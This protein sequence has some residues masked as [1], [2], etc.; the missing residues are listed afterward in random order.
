MS[1]QKLQKLL[2]NLF[3]GSQ[4]IWQSIHII[5]AHPS[6]SCLNGDLSFF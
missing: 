2:V 6:F 4:I 5:V 3:W 1:G